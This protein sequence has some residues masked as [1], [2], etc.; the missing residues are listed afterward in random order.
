MNPFILPNIYLQANDYT[1][2]ADIYK[3]VA[4]VTLVSPHTLKG[5]RE[6]GGGGGGRQKVQGCGKA[7]KGKTEE[8]RE[9]WGGG[10]LLREPCYNTQVRRATSI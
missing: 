3:S 6:A 9:G 10:L 4:N 2:A 1:T 5:E 7:G 8:K